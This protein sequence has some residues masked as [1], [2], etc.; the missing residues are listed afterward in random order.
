MLRNAKPEA[1]PQLRVILISLVRGR[2]CQVKVERERKA[3]RLL[4]EAKGCVQL[5]RGSLVPRVQG[6]T[7]R[8]TQVQRLQRW[9]RLEE[10]NERLFI[11]VGSEGPHQRVHQNRIRVPKGE[12]GVAKVARRMVHGVARLIVVRRLVLRERRHQLGRPQLGV[13]VC[14]DPHVDQVPGDVPN[15]HRG[16]AVVQVRSVLLG[17]N[18][19]RLVPLGTLHMVRR[20]LLKVTNE[21]GVV[22]QLLDPAVRGDERK[23]RLGVQRAPMVVEELSKLVAEQVKL[24][25]SALGRRHAKHTP[26]TLRTNS[27]RRTRP[28]ARAR[29]FGSSQ[30]LKTLLHLVEVV[31]VDLRQPRGERGRLRR[32]P[33]GLERL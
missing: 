3:H 6:D 21:R 13:R 18:V 23:G 14:R 29:R 12:D 4:K 22:Q 15:E 28:G 10:V 19:Q 33:R 1:A 2:H 30:R 25:R 24:G 9:R 8:G 5:N 16:K 32:I 31:Q 17:N 27:Q 11:L 7:Q 20:H 26:R